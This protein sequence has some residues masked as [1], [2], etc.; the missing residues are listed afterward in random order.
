MSDLFSN[1]RPA[2][3]EIYPDMFLLANFVETIPLMK[4]VAN[5]LAVS[6]FRKMMTPNG[7][8]T[9]IALTN[10]GDYGW[11]SDRQGYR[12]SADDPITNKPWHIMPESFLMLANNASEAAG[13]H[14]FIPDACLINHYPIGSKLNSH[15]DKNEQ[16]FNHPIVSI[17]IGLPATFQVF[18]NQRA[19]KPLNVELYDGDIVVWGGSSRLAYHG[20]KSIKPDPHNP[21][22]VERINITFRKAK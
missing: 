9:G 10:C 2:V 14:Q 19:G 21:N 4:S 13:Y 15:Q 22:L 18:G 5:I 17:S 6:P 1:T 8:K 11:I 3:E 16:N 12:Y 7:H 20:I